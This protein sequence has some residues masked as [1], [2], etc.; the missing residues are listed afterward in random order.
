MPPRKLVA[1]E[2]SVGFS[3]SSVSTAGS[4][5]ALVSRSVA[6]HALKTV[7]AATRKGARRRAARRT[8]SRAWD[9][10][11]IPLRHLGVDGSGSVQ[12]RGQRLASAKAA[13]HRG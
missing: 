7:A 11:Q 10:V 5:E 1:K 8:K 6:S 3:G 12:A 2:I 9:I 13:A 4:S